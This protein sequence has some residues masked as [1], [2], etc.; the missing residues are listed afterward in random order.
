MSNIQDL[1]AELDSLQD[2]NKASFLQNYFKTG[3]GEYGEGDTFIGITVPIQRIAAKKYS[4]L[5]L[6]DIERLVKH[7]IHEYRLT[8]LMI[9]VFQ[10]IKANVETKKRIFNFYIRNKKFVNNW[11]LVDSSAPYIVGAYLFDKEKGPLYKLT[12]SP[13][14]WE[15]RIAI[16]ATQYFIRQNNFSE[17]IKIAG[18]LLE[19]THDLIHKAA[20]WMLREVGNKSL[21]TEIEFLNK[22]YKKMPRTM[23]RYA[24]EKFPEEKRVHYLKGKV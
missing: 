18:M 17:T 20:G 23:L 2:S 9:L 14:V 5:P 21:E 19:D 10:Y 11:D 22:H 16:I 4:D 6:T 15:R 8:G 7:K 1:I 24:I 13:S 3:K 12:R